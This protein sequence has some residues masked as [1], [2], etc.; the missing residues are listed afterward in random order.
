MLD[1]RTIYFVVGRIVVV[2]LIVLEYSD[3]V[4][5]AISGFI[6]AE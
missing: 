4:E 1:R 2:P 6:G 3:R 5:A